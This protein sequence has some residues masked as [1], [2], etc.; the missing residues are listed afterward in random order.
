MA[1][2]K[3]ASRKSA[4]K[5]ASK[6]RKSRAAAKKAS[7]TR[8]Q[9]ATGK[10]AAATRKR[11]AV[12][13]KSLATRKTK[14]AVVTRAKSTADTNALTNSAEIDGRIAIVRNNLREL[15]EQAASRS[16]ASD[17]ELM[18]QRIAEQE[19]KL[20]LLMKQREELAQRGS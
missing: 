19:A 3:S 9:R 13:K 4:A 7:K 1:A 5:K 11:R 18:S 10:K 2:S 12:V 14:S 15:V 17:E 16:G 20:E 8:K 6:T